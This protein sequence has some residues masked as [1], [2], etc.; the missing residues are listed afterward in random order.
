MRVCLP[1]IAAAAAAANDADG[2]DAADS[3][4]ACFSRAGHK[5]RRRL[6]TRAGPKLLIINV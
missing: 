1:G 3:L 2:D 4:I 5:D 6:V